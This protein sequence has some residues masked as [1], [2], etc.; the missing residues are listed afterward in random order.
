MAEVQKV[1][2]KVGPTAEDMARWL[3]V[4]GQAQARWAK[5]LPVTKD[6]P[7]LKRKGLREDPDP[8]ILRADGSELLVPMIDTV[9]GPAGYPIVSLQRILPDGSKFFLPGGRTAGTRAPTIGMGYVRFGADN[10]PE[11]GQTVYI[12]EGY[13]TGWTISHVMK[14]P[15]VVAF[16]NGNLKRVAA[17]I[18]SAYRELD[19]V[20]AADN[21]RFKGAVNPGVDAA[22]KAIPVGRSWLYAPK[23]GVAIPSFTSDAKGGKDFND[24]WI[25]EGDTA[26]RYWLNP[27]NAKAARTMPLEAPQE[28]PDEVK[29]KK[30]PKPKDAKP[31]GVNGHGP[32]LPPAS[33]EV[34]APEPWVTTK[35]FRLLGH[36]RG[37]YFYLPESGGQI[38]ALTAEK[39]ER[40][41]SLCRLAP[42]SWWAHHFSKGQAVD[43]KCAADALMTVSHK[44]G[45]YRPDNLRGR[46]CWR[47]ADDDAESEDTQPIVL[48]LGDRMVV[49]G[50]KQYVKPG[51]YESPGGYMYEYQPHVRGPHLKP[52]TADEGRKVLDICHSFMWKDPIAG[53]L[54]AGWIL[55]APIGGALAWRP[56]VWLVGSKGSGKTSVINQVIVPL[57]TGAVDV[58]GMALHVVGNTSEAGIRQELRADSFPVVFDEAEETEGVG[59]Q[60]QR[61]IGL[62]RQSS[63]ESDSRTLKGTT[64]GGSLQFRIRSMFCFASIGG[65]VYQEADKSRIAMLHLRGD[66]MDAKAKLDH[67]AALEPRIVDTISRDTGRRLLSRSLAMLR[68]GVLPA[69]VKVFRRMGAG[70]FGDQRAG[71]QY[72]TLFAGA[73]LMQS[74]D[75]P[76]ESEA[77]EMLMTD[78][79][80]TH[81]AEQIPEGR[82]A[83]Q[84]LLQQR[85]RI[86][87]GN[88]ARTFAIGQL[89]DVA[90]NGGGVCT[91]A[92][93]LGVLT[94]IG[95]RVEM[96]DAGYVLLI[97]LTSEWIKEALANTLYAHGLEVVIQ[98][99]EGVSLTDRSIKFHRGMI[100]RAIKVP[101]HL[102]TAE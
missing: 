68:S 56:H 28:D 88:G 13:A 41:S 14:A 96:G 71:D 48:H 92:E 73:W 91:E 59:T 20:V 69:T 30:K 26:V 57:L 97:S 24:L 2:P 9:K 5:A 83:L 75:P 22:R 17:F 32:D 99:L 52:L 87:T 47:E 36:D 85:E 76:S 70:A 84:I 78:E 23:G 1:G 44:V 66:Q 31:K 55:L 86:D 3:E 16:S 10:K 29:P 25:E 18:S 21:D 67:W 53:D 7:Y 94:Q 89:I 35:R 15:V 34:A 11:P 60:V 43:V 77:R 27:D 62:A 33:V 101:F 45:I 81:Q 49:P 74:D 61:V 100:T 72:G 65:A 79:L 95:M 50:M 4:A 64:H 42:L 90:A 6:H 54:L 12:C 38:V 37:T 58:G 98:G 51:D 93:A 46:G 40:V 102:L 80:R 8:A 63:S 39:H 19:I 82:K